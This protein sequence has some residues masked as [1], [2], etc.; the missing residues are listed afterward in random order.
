MELKTILFYDI[1][2]QRIPRKPLTYGPCQEIYDHVFNIIYLNT[3]TMIRPFF[4]QLM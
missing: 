3:P 1:S 2:S 4:E